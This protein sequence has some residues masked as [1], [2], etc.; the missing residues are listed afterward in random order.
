[1]NY[2]LERHINCNFVTMQ[3][4]INNEELIDYKLGFLGGLGMILCPYYGVAL[5]IH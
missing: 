3:N 4:M 5:H 1:M 2:G